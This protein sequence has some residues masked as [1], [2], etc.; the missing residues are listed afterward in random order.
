MILR[1]P[2]GLKHGGA[3]HAAFSSLVP[4][5]D[6]L[7]AALLSNTRV[8]YNTIGVLGEHS[9]CVVDNHAHSSAR[10][11]TEGRTSTMPTQLRM[12]PIQRD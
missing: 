9:A 6:T 8:C 10:A 12:A 4:L 2:Y 1:M 11:G 3:T 5:A 7:G